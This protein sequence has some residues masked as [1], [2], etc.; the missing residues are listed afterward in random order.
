VGAP[1]IDALRGGEA[2]PRSRKVCE[3]STCFAKLATWRLTL[4]QQQSLRLRQIWPH[5][6]SAAQGHLCGT[7]S[8]EPRMEEREQVAKFATSKPTTES[9]ASHRTPL[10]RQVEA[11]APFSSIPSG[12][13]KAASPPM[14]VATSVCVLGEHPERGV[15]RGRHGARESHSGQRRLSDANRPC[16]PIAFAR[17]AL[18]DA[19]TSRRSSASPAYRWRLGQLYNLGCRT[20]RK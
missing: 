10:P 4:T 20:M 18:Q 1:L 13:L 8:S 14:R 7:E 9:S 15:Q 11:S 6:G 3:P 5:T 2:A 19:N 17:C 12:D 16:R